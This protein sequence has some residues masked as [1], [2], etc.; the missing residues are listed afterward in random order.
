MESLGEEG[1]KRL[2]ALVVEHAVAVGFGDPTILSADTTAQELPIGYPHEAGILKGLAERCSRA[3]EK[4]KSKGKRG[5]KQAQELCQT[6]V[7]KAKEYHLFAKTKERKDTILRSMVAQTRKL[8]R[9]T[10]AIESRYAEQTERVVQSACSQLEKMGS[11]GETLLPQILYWLKTGTVAKGKILHAGL[12]NARAIVRNKVGKKVEFGLQYL[13]CA[14]GG[15]YLLAE[16]IDKP[17]GETKMPMKALGIYQ[18]VF[19]EETVPDLFVFDR[20]GSSEKNRERLKDAGVEKIG[21]QPKGNAPWHVHGKDREAVASE[22]AMIEGRIGSLKSDKYGFNKPKDRKIST[23]R[24]S[25]QRSV[26]SY[27]LNKLMRDLVSQ[28]NEATA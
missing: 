18:S 1:V 12:T 26:A 15:G 2:N 20:G 19:T 17:T 27:N 8:L 11:V 21:I 23:V 28:S 24:S 25:G 14:I 22:R 16:L 7:F 5:F 9:E 6:I 13:L 4:L 3:L 10:A